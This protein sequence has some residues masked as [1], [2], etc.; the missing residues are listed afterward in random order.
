MD[1]R[2]IRIDARTL[3]RKNRKI[4]IYSFYILGILTMCFQILNSGW[5]ILLTQILLVT[6]PHGYVYISLRVIQDQKI[7]SLR[8]RD[9]LIGI[10]DIFKYLPSYLTRMLA[11]YLSSFACL[12]PALLISTP[13]SKIT[14]YDLMSQVVQYIVQRGVTF[15]FVV[16]QLFILKPISFIF[17]F[18]SIVLYI[19]LNILFIF[20]PYIVEDYDYSWLEALVKSI[21]LIKGHQSELVH[22]ILSFVP[23]FVYYYLLLLLM[24]I[25]MYYLGT[26]GYIIYLIISIIIQIRLFLAEYHLS[27]ASFYLKIRDEKKEENELFK[28]K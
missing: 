20:V 28:I 12:L 24:Q 5:L 18:G 4:M 26:V 17:L 7:T 2:Q 3:Y 14:T 11:I 6:L 22:L 10:Y 1:I 16:S 27:I 19:L 23:N 25:P 8:I 9:I 13:G 21:E 15:N